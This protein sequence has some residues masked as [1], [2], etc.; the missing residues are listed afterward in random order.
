MNRFFLRWFI[1]ALAIAAAVWAIPGIHLDGGVVP[2]IGIALIFGLVNAIIRPLI[3]FLTCPLIILT[4]GLGTLVLNAGMLLLTASI[5]QS[6]NLGFRVDGFW[7]AFWGAIVISLVSV[8]L[9]T[10]LGEK[11]ERPEPRRDND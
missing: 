10:M 6:F 9:S 11:K 7:P 3:A 8:V 1:N 4:L 5:S 2:L